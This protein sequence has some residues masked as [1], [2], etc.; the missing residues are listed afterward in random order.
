M[1]KNRGIRWKKKLFKR[2]EIFFI[3]L[4][5]WRFSHKIILQSWKVHKLR[6]QQRGAICLGFENRLFFLR[7]EVRVRVIEILYRTRCN[8]LVNPEHVPYY[9]F[10]FQH[11]T[12]DTK[13]SVHVANNN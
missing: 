6:A 7:L 1:T 4:Q 2:R 5:I 13:Y 9:S 3:Y 10:R 12:I 8:F 11:K